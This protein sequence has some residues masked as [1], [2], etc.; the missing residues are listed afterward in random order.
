MK[1]IV[2]NDEL[3]KNFRSQS[4]YNA[5]VTGGCS[6]R[7][8]W[9]LNY[10]ID[11]YGISY[12]KDNLNYII[13]IDKV[14]TPITFDFKLKNYTFN[15]SDTGI[16]FLYVLSLIKKNLLDN[17]D[18]LKIVELGCGFGALTKIYNDKYGFKEYN[19]I[20][21][22]YVNKLIE[23][24]LNKYYDNDIMSKINFLTDKTIKNEKYDIFISYY[25]FTEINHS[26]KMFYFNKIIKNCNCGIIF[27]RILDKDK[28][29][30]INDDLLS[31]FKKYF[32]FVKVELDKP[33]GYNNKKRI[34]KKKPYIL[35]F[36]K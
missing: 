7:G 20:D 25:A 8:K 11:N 17:L 15:S 36:K 19:I 29:N 1:E 4:I 2:K 18:N 6:E 31:E 22:P 34:Q 32:S 13:D 33:Y 3:F 14:G 30:S 21:L 12:I 10:L 5:V 16:T 28:N 24:Y 35:Y 27:G 26:L 9:Y 23:K